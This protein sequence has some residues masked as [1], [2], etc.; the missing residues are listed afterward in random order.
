MKL[1]NP[2][3]KPIDHVIKEIM[4]KRNDLKNILNKKQQ[5]QNQQNKPSQNPNQNS[6]QNNANRDKK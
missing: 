4:Q 1:N 5:M 6:Q 2:S 3:L